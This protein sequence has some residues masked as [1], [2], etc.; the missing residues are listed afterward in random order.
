LKTP[1][2]GLFAH[3]AKL[4]AEIKMGATFN[5][6]NANYDRIMELNANCFHLGVVG[7]E[8]VEVAR[9]HAACHLRQKGRK[10]LGTQMNTD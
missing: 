1:L 3:P 2:R 8:V 5:T 9:F 6:A 7:V 10:G 4:F